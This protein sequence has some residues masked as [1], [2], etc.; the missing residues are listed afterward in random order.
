MS[1]Y[2]HLDSTVLAEGGFLRMTEDRFAAPDGSEFVRWVVNH[3]GAVVGVP[4]TD[5][6]SVLLVRQFRAAAR[7]WMLEL[8]AGKLDVPGEE[9][10]A[11]AARELAEEVAH[12]PGRLVDLGGFWNSPGF[13][14]EYTHVFLATDLVPCDDGY[15]LKEEE[16]DMTVER[17]RLDDALA[18]IDDGGIADA[19]TIVGLLRAQR[20]LNG[21]GDG[22]S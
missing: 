15:E 1:G 2:R 16:R 20:W 5:D 7:D 6:G 22:A 9:P 17:L 13:C 8:P 10:A 19:K 3:P 12:Q 14:T 18:R 4:V 21:N 11:A